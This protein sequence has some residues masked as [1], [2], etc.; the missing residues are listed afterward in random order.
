MNYTPPNDIKDPGFQ[1]DSRIK[2][3]MLDEISLFT[4]PEIQ[5]LCASARQHGY[6][7]IGL[8]DD[9]QNKAVFIGI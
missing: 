3:L 6:T 4:A 5:A 2:I 7:I 9:K 1:S 8:G